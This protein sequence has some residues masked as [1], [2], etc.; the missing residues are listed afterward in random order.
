MLV[1]SIAVSHLIV[2][3]KKAVSGTEDGTDNKLFSYEKQAYNC[4]FGFDG[5]VFFYCECTGV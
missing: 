5:D 1:G 3:F 4:W 2:N